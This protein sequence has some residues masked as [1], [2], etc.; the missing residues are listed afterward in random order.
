MPFNSGTLEQ[1]KDI[2]PGLFSKIRAMCAISRYYNKTY[3][4]SL[5]L[6]S[7]LIRTTLFDAISSS[8]TDATRLNHRL[9]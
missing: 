8:S 1:M 5:F 9:P 6:R 3:V 7:F 4:P 2:L